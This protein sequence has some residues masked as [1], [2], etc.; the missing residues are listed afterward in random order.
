MNKK[1]AVFLSTLFCCFLGGMALVSL[2]LPKQTF[3]PMEN[4]YLQKAPALTPERVM[5]GSFMTDA[6]NYVS[7]HIAG[8]DLWVAMKAWNE[9]LSGKQEN[10]SSTGWTSRTW[11]SWSRTCPMWTI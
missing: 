5:N 4:R 1:F 9:R 3:S 6:E 7:D 8:R 11:T 10:N 2:I